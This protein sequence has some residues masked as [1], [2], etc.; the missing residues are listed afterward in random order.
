[1]PLAAFASL[2]IFAAVQRDA[3]ARA[4]IDFLALLAAGVL[5]AM[6]AVEGRRSRV[7]GWS[8]L[9]VAVAVWVLAG[10]LRTAAVTAVLAVGLALAAMAGWRR[11]GGAATPGFTVPMALGLQLL[12]RCDL[13]LPP[14]L[15]AR[16]LV[17]V[18]ALPAAAGL[19]TSVLAVYLGPWRAL[20]AAAAVGV[21]A[22]GWNVTTTL[23][24]VASAAGVLAADAGRPRWLR[25][26][27]AALLLVPFLRQPAIGLLIV[28]AAVA[29]ATRGENPAASRAAPAARLL[30][31]AAALAA[32]GLLPAA[33]GWT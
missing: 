16:T 5:A 4:E 3:S 27:A 6:A 14:L 11:L 10:P 32:L 26:A 25:S 33:R 31:P 15:D 18:V 21:L 22:P 9:V 17:S 12:L 30:V 13:L 2:R 29:L 7:A 19:A 23:A 8:S 24:L 28:L 1:M 20:V